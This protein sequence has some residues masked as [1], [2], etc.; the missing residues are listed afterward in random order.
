[1]PLA[2]ESQGK[3]PP[4]VFLHG[5]F[6]SGRNWGSIARELKSHFQVFLLD[7]RNHGNSPHSASHTLKNLVADL[8][9]WQLANVKEPIHLLGHSMGGLVAMAYALHFPQN[10]QSL[11]IVDIAPRSYPFLHE[12]EFALLQQDFRQAENRS[13]VDGAAAAIVSDPL[14]RGFLLTNLERTSSGY[15][16]KINVPVL[17]QSR[18]TAEFPEQS[19][20]WNGPAL[21]IH[22]S[23]SAY[24]Q[25]G[26][27]AVCRSFFPAARFESIRGGGHWLHVS[28]KAEFLQ[29]LKGWLLHA[30]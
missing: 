19:G 12:R 30:A 26:D 15:Q 20:T 3:G 9:A 24:F 21:F 29:I 18:L 14:V 8:H 16:W 27:E 25:K 6:G 23:E 22:G 5:L 1:M 17:Y 4:L 11:C 7:Q 13:Q 10:I 28:H 2:F